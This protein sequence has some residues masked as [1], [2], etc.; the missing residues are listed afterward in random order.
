MDSTPQQP[1]QAPVPSTPVDQTPAP[2]EPI[3]PVLDGV[4]AP[5]GYDGP[6]PKPGMDLGNPA[7]W[8]ESN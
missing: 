6:W 2:T 7:S 5:T 3:Q 1:N 8:L 4:P